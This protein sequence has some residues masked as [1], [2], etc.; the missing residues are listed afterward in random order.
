LPARSLTVTGLS[1]DARLVFPFDALPASA[2]GDLTACT[3][4]SQG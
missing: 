3:R 2:R 4:A 1:G